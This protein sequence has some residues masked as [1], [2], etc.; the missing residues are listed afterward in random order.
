[1]KLLLILFLLF[2]CNNIIAQSLA[3]L[4]DSLRKKANKNSAIKKKE[5]KEVAQVAAPKSKIENDDEV[6]A[7]LISLALK[8]TDMTSA[9]ANIRIAEISRN[10]ANSTLLGSVSIGANANEFVVNNSPAANFFPKYNVGLIMPLDV[11]AKSKAEKRTA[12]QVIIINKSEKDQL[13]KSIKT[14]VLILYE[15]YKEK[16]ELVEL[17]KIAMEDDIAA[18]DRAQRDFK[19]EIITLQELNVIYKASIFEKA[20]LTTKEKELNIAGIQL[21]EII[22][23]PLQRAL[24]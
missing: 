11:F 7:K 16:K 17:Q 5:T 2:N 15:T 12:D 6:K 18:Y 8:N 19:D 9:N 23:M 3:K 24:L 4:P 20:I 21:E 1:M 22:G 14:R 10:K 13:V